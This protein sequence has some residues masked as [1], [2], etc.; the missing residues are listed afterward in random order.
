MHAITRRRQQTYPNLRERLRHFGVSSGASTSV[1]M[2]VKMNFL[3]LAV[4][5]CLDVYNLHNVIVIV[6]WVLLR[7]DQIQYKGN[8][9]RHED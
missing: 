9:S 1:G 3:L 6:I 8:Q 5:L 4:R 2:L 7:E